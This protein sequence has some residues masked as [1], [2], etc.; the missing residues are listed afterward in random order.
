MVT[1]ASIIHKILNKFAVWYNLRSEKSLLPKLWLVCIPVY[2]LREKAWDNSLSLQHPIR[3]LQS[4]L[5]FPLS[6]ILDC[7]SSSI[8]FLFDE[9]FFHRLLYIL[10]SLPS[11]Y[12]HLFTIVSPLT[13]LLFH[14]FSEWM[15]VVS[16]DSSYGGV[17]D[18]SV[19]MCWPVA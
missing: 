1:P 11:T 9:Q 14:P 12:L 10:H 5:P 19:Q 7:H 16:V 6:S 2:Q 4:L 17:G 3:S 15:D 8:I 18:Q 13:L